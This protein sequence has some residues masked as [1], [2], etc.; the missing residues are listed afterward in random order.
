MSDIVP[1]P[2]A[3]QRLGHAEPSQFQSSPNSGSVVAMDH[4]D[5]ETVH[6]LMRC[7]RRIGKPYLL[8]KFNREGFAHDLE[9]ETAEGS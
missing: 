9:K 4:I 2:N 6:D 5:L 3:L 1:F 8:D 7:F